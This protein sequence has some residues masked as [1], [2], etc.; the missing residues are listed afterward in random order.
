MV[1]YAATKN[2]AKNSIVREVRS[3]LCERPEIGSGNG[4]T[5][6]GR[7]LGHTM[8]SY[9]AGCT[10]LG[11]PIVHRVSCMLLIE[12][13]FW[14]LGDLQSYSPQRTLVRVSCALVV[15]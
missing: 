8:V 13:Q 12:S 1:T 9:W 15:A 3:R 10:H 4:R 11:H 14:L 5:T 6:P 2:I 7:T